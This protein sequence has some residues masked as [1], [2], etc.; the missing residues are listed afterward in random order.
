MDYRKEHISSIFLFL[1]SVFICFFSYR[2]SIGSL[3]A[4]CSG[5]FP[6]FLGVI[7]G[8]LSIL[9]FASSMK[10]KKAASEKLA[11]LESGII[12]KNIF[13]ALAILF[14]YPLLLNVL[15]FLL[16]SF[17]FGAVFLRVI[18]PQRWSV[19]FGVAAAMALA[20]FLIF[21]YWLNILFPTG[22]FRI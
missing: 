2:I 10:Q 4:P 12:W 22:I 8:L 18:E 16:V 5:F 15:G 11:T 6:F 19:V 13:V 17:L 9:N 3:R 14:L 20:F 21:Q 7:L 1:F